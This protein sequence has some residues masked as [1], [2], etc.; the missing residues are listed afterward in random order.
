MSVE[1]AKQFPRRLFFNDNG[2]LITNTVCFASWGDDDVLP[3]NVPTWFASPPSNASA[4]T[5]YETG[6][7]VAH[8]NKYWLATERATHLDE[9][10]VSSK[11]KEVF[12]DVTKDGINKARQCSF[13]Y[14]PDQTPRDDFFPART[15]LGRSYGKISIFVVG[16]YQMDLIPQDASQKAGNYKTFGGINFR[17]FSDLTA[18]INCYITRNLDDVIVS[19]LNGF[20]SDTFRFHGNSY[21]PVIVNCNINT[22]DIELGFGSYDCYNSQ[23]NYFLNTETSRG[24]N[25]RQSIFEGNKIK[26][27]NRPDVREYSEYCFFR[28]NV[29]I[30]QANCFQ[31]LTTNN[32]SNN[33]IFNVPGLNQS[34][35]AE[36]KFNIHPFD[37]TFQLNSPNFRGRPQDFLN[38]ANCKYGITLYNS[39]E[40][41]YKDENGAN[42]TFTPTKDPTLPTITN[43]G[44]EMIQ[45]KNL[46]N[47]VENIELEQ[48]HLIGYHLLNPNFDSFNPA[49]GVYS[50]SNDFNAPTDDNLTTGKVGIYARFQ[51]KNGNITPW[52]FYPVYQDLGQ[53]TNGK[54]VLDYD[55]NGT[56]VSGRPK[57]CKVQIR[58]YYPNGGCDSCMGITIV[59]K[60]HTI[61]KIEINDST[62]KSFEVSELELSEDLDQT[63]MLDF[64]NNAKEAVL[65][66][67]FGW[68]K[69][70]ARISFKISGE[71][72]EG[73]AFEKRIK[74]QPLNIA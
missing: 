26:A 54:T 8:S 45:W 37:G 58:T 61:E 59:A 47:G 25:S 13:P 9:P 48:I 39:V 3:E 1:Y 43:L 20:F 5:F 52:E 55:F 64:D 2:D 46:G 16:K 22:L 11:Y 12:R 15:G 6:L 57:G 67:P 18:I 36:P 27:L 19:L 74:N 40:A 73:E 63:I 29:I 30:A 4:T 71:N 23:I 32:V 17:Y 24:N 72:N 38:I 21:D 51:Q 14:N 49:T 65:N 62:A 28:D 10:G 66:Q 31:D 56:V 69:K 70:S 68:A 44:F 42:L 60:M 35:A 7:A 50:V 34:I 53:D 33:N 41:S